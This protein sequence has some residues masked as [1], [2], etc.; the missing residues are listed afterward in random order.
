MKRPEESLEILKFVKLHHWW[1]TAVINQST[2]T[3][4]D[5]KI[6]RIHASDSLPFFKSDEDAELLIVIAG[7]IVHVII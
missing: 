5:I 2:M 3:D 1:A 6:T 7:V 4:K